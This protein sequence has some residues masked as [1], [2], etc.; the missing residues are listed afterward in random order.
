[1]AD[2]PVPSA[3]SAAARALKLFL[4]GERCLT[5]KCTVERRAYPPGQHGRGRIKQSS[6]CSSCARSRR[7][8]A[9]YGVLEKQF[10]QLLREGRSA[11][12]A[13]PARTCCSLLERRLDNVV[14]RLGFA[15]SRAQARQLVGHGHFKVNGRRV[16]IPSYQVKPDDVITMR[17]RSAAE[18]VIRDADRPHG[19][20]LPVAPG[21]PR[22]PGRQGAAPPG[23]RRDRHSGP[24]AADRRALLEV[25]LVEWAG[26]RP[27]P[28]LLAA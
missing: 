12:R 25:T 28:A 9:I 17:E 22:Q 5:E 14:Y 6:T 3:S 27:V 8:A 16:N 21:R 2:P 23:A 19:V 18:T 4:K 11:R 7:R 24:G 15:S 20:R 1:M 26:V 13:S 10:R